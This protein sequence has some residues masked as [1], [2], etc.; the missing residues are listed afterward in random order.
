MNL[1]PFPYGLSAVG[2][3]TITPSGLVY[4]ADDIPQI[5]TN[6]AG[7]RAVAS[8][9]IRLFMVSRCSAVSSI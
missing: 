1:P 2:G 5:T 8:L 6:T 3:T 7:G 9:S 4:A